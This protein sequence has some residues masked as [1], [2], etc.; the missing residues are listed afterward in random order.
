[1]KV[2]YIPYVFLFVLWSQGI[3]AQ[4][5]INN[6]DSASAREVELGEIVIKA[7]RANSKLKEMH[8]SVSLISS[9]FMRENEINSLA[10]VSSVAPNLF[11]PEYGS[12]LT[13]PVYI[14]GIGSRINA[15]S[16]GLYVDNV[17]YF[18]KAAFDFDFFDMERIEVLRGPQGTLYG[19]NTM[20]GIINVF[21]LSPMNYQ[22]SNI[23]VSTG[24]YGLFSVN[25]GYY[26]KINDK[27]GYSLAVNYIHND[28]Y[29][30][31]QFTGNKVDKSNSLG[32]RMR[33]AWNVSKKLTVE[34]IAGAEISRQGAYP[35]ALYNDSLQIPE[36]IN[37]NQ[38]SSYDRDLFSDALVAKYRTDKFEVISTTAYQLL[39]DEQEIDQDF[40]ADSLFFVTQSQW[41][42]MISEEITI[43][44]TGPGKYNWLF[45]G[46]G[47]FQAFDNAVD[48]DQY[49]TNT[50]L[51]KQYDHRIGGFALFHQSTLNDF[52]AKNLSVTGGIRMDF[53]NDKLEYRYDRSRNGP[54]VNIADTVYPSLQSLQFL[55]KLAVNYKVAGNNFYIVVAKGY[56]TGGFNST[57]E[58]PEDLTFDPEHSW[59]YEAGVKSSFFK[60][61]L[62]ADVAL[63]YIDWKNQQ[64]YQTVP[65]GRGSML[66]N[67]GHSV[68]KGVEFTLRTLTGKGFEILMAYG[69]THASFLSYEVDS[70]LDYN[71]NMIPYV[72]RHT[73]ALQANKSVAFKSTSFLDKIDFNILYRGAGE[74]FWNE[75]NSHHQ[76]FYGIL[77]AKVSFFI[78]K[79]Q[80]DIWGR[81]LLGTEY[82][83]FYFESL[84]N[85]YVQPGKALQLGINL[86]FKV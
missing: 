60:N 74:I 9:S 21:T 15:P 1:M 6:A 59:N 37:Y 81:N 57:F 76:P 14:R 41:Q 79:L 30:T 78:K 8:A 28:G 16:V 71:G 40:T 63:Y 5:Q 85:K 62:Y 34:N 2:I 20:G 54:P 49:A 64:I 48:V 43:R 18:E 65:S 25:A 51:L 66:K 70:T 3:H 19:R 32:F 31:N 45:G 44:S 12:K 55:P 29:F 69:Y 72:P 53:E 38:Y 58:R 4:N 26:A 75:E 61:H 83:A 50:A 46:Y 10:E 73:L 39:K 24:N 36:D 86:S 47:F 52:I 27:F 17:P 67:A 7:S 84:G 77:D 68:S 13:S 80:F 35:Y 11:M 33:L 23:K 42:H 22:G 82:E 56:K